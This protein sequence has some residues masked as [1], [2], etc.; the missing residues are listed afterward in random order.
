MCA[1]TITEIYNFFNQLIQTAACNLQQQASPITNLFD[2][3]VTSSN[4]IRV[5][6]T[7]K[8][9]STNNNIYKLSPVALKTAKVTFLCHGSAARGTPR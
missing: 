2:D 7:C 8:Q 1:G 9:Q 3:S 4:L 6:L 5:V